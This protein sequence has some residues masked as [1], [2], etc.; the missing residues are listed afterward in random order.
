MM[1][2]GGRRIIVDGWGLDLP[3]SAYLHDA[4]AGRSA[5]VREISYQGRI[6]RLSDS[7]ISALEA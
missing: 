3:F 7:S 5:W 6:E 2:G 1:N 4:G